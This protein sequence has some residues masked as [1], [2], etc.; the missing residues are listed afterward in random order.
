MAN[1]E[2]RHLITGGTM[3]S[4]WHP[5]RDTAVPAAI[6][7]SAAY[8]SW[9]ESHGVEP[10]THEQLMLKD[11][12][13][14]TLDDRDLLA[15]KIAEASANRLL[16]TSGTFL[17]PDMAR[18]A[19]DHDMARF[20]PQLGK[21][22]V[23]TGALTPIKGFEMSDGGFNL[24]MGLALLQTDRIPPELSV[25]A[26]MNGAAIPG[27]KLRKDHTTAVFSGTREADD[28]LGY[29]RFTLIPAGGTIDFELDGLDGL[30]PADE[31]IIPT[32]LR[33]QVRSKKKFEASKPILKDSRALTDEDMDLVVDVIRASGDEHILVTSGLIRIGELR[34]RVSSALTGDDRDRKIVLTGSKYILRMA[35]NTDAPFNLGYGLGNLGFVDPGAHVAVGG[36]ILS[37]RQNPILYTYTKDEQ[38]KLAEYISE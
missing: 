4:T 7:T 8:L 13:E 32:Y 29:D 37:P 22:A 15:A 6:S 16:V 10:M 26:T 24:G 34:A 19:A 31:S 3:D 1:N 33:D 30:Q 21:R 18:E 2:V 11:S 27:N 36:R 5:E 38:K 35:G 20:Y 23:F 28:L 14:T 12:R 9:M 25:L 17:M